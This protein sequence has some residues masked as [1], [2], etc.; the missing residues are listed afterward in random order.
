MKIFDEW[1]D[2]IGNQTDETFPGF[3]EGYSNAE[4]HAYSLLLQTK[5]QKMSGTFK[6]LSEKFDVEPVLFMGFLDGINS[7]LKKEIDIKNVEDDT[8]IDLDVDLEKLFFNMH[9]AEADHLYT[10]PEWDNLLSEE[11]RDQIHREYKK[12]KTIV[13][14]KTPGRNDPCPCGSGKKYKK[15]CGAVV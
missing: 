6:E 4:K 7:S 8:Q 12:S 14:G 10:L 2:L 5:D 3:W 15:C 13:K 1:N 9:K 11:R